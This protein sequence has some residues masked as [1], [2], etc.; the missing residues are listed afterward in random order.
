M[1]EGEGH[2]SRLVRDVGPASASVCTNAT[3]MPHA[4]PESWCF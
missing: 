4:T 1:L 3:P 2:V